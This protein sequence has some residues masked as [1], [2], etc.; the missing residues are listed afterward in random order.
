MDVSNKITSA[1]NFD[2]GNHIS[3]IYRTDQ[4]LFSLIIPFFIDGLQK[5]NKCMYVIGE[6]SSNEI[7]NAFNDSGFDLLPHILAKDFILTSHKNIYFKDGAFDVKVVT[8]NLVVAESDALKQGYS[9]L[10]IAGSTSW[11]TKEISIMPEFIKYEKLMNEFIEFSSIIAACLYNESLF[12][13]KILVDVLYSHPS[14]YLYDKL[15]KNL[16]FKSF[17][18]QQ[19][20]NSQELTYEE[21]TR[22]LYNK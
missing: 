10:R 11:V 14:I 2:L 18:N 16:Y 6:Y 21:I 9:G 20:V 15:V 1:N 5:H 3:F 8:S 7:I 17:S 22:I 4:E 19:D 13:H 12:N